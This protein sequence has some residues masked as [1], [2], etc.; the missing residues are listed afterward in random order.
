[1]MEPIEGASPAPT[2]LPNVQSSVPPDPTTQA[3]QTRTQ[4]DFFRGGMPLPLDRRMKDGRTLKEHLEKD[5]IGW[6]QEAI[7]AHQPRINLIRRLEKL[8]RGEKPPKSFPYEGCHNTSIPVTRSRVDA[9]VVRI[10][11]A[12]FGQAKMFIV[13]P[14]TPE[15]VELQKPTEDALEWWQKH[16][17]QLKKKL[18]SPSM[19]AIKTGTGFV[20]MPF[21]NKKRTVVRPAVSGDEMNPNVKSVTINT[22]GGGVPGVKETVTTFSGPDVISLDRIDVVWSP[23]ATDI[24]DA[25]VCGFKT[26][27]RKPQVEIRVKQGFYLPDTM[28]KISKSSRSKE[29]TSRAAGK[30]L[31][32]QDKADIYEIWQVWAKYDVDG[33]GEEDDIVLSV[34]VSSKTVMRGMFNEFFDGFRP[35]IPITF[36]PLENSIDGEG[37]CEI[38]EKVQEEIDSVHNQRLDRMDQINSRITI[39]MANCG[40]D[41]FQA[42]PGTIWFVHDSP[43]NVIMELE[44][45]DIYPSTWQEESLLNN[46][47]DQLS[48]V[49]PAVMGQTTSERPVAKETFAML[50]EANKKFK[51]GIDNYRDNTL[52]RIGQ[53]AV[54]QM[55]QFKPSYSYS[56][57][58]GGQFEQKMLN[59]PWGYMRDSVKIEIAAS[60]EMFNQE[61]RRE[62]DLTLYG[63]QND[64][65]TKMGGM[66][67]SVFN[68][69][70]PPPFKMFVL[71]V[72]QAGIDTMK[73]IYE[74]FGRRDADKMI[75]DLQKIPGLQEAVMMYQPPPGAPG[76]PGG[77]PGGN[78]QEGG[79]GGPP[80]EPDTQAPMSGPP[81]AQGG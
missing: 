59:L 47:A 45:S 64:F 44:R 65:Y 55:A 43:Q 11:D 73:N 41:D 20:Y 40:L 18:Y 53:V 52:N 19:Q 5:V 46:Y 54:E 62:I 42:V 75:I 56:V 16:Q 17:V 6:L 28:E 1:M 58:Q 78:P 61:A 63:I 15:M 21:V 14:Q 3:E 25:L 13:K 26:E 69:T 36:Y 70:I 29:K 33:D 12:A 23:E 7:E 49:T 9:V 38:M 2:S 71:Q 32:L 48:G 4:E 76:G 8:Y 10:F 27:L 51:F 30:G 22:S 72:A 24:Q 35:L 31:K 81:T 66:L 57:E 79:Q 80:T 60:T 37:L 74:D 39:A 67:Q 34:N 68:P 50:Q 77:P